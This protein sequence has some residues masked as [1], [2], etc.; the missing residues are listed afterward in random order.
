MEARGTELG[1][2][3]RSNPVENMN[4]QLVI[5]L[6]QMTEF[7]EKQETRIARLEQSNLETADDVALKGFMKF[8]PLKFDGEPDEEKAERWMET[9]ED[10]YA[11][12]NY[13]EE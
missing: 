13:T 9:L 6:T 2:G 12:L 8:N 7:F 5:A 1:E 10:I 3:F 11:A 4:A